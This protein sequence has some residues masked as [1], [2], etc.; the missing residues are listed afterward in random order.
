MYKII[1]APEAKKGLKTIAKIY[2]KGIVEAIDS[3]KDDPYLGKPLTRELTGKYSH[4]IGVYRVIYK[5][6][7]ND[8]AVYVI[9][10]GHRATIYQ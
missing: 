2:R 1:V 10:A 5:I 3:L 7:E 4:K 6:N 9:S 8:K